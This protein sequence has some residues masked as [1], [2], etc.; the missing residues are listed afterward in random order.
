MGSLP[1]PLH[2]YSQTSTVTNMRPLYVFFW[3]AILNIKLGCCIQCVVSGVEKK[4]CPAEVATCAIRQT[5]DTGL[6]TF[7][8]KGE[9]GC[10]VQSAGLTCY[11]NS[12]NCNKD[13]GSAGYNVAAASAGGYTDIL[14]NSAVP[15]SISLGLLVVLLLL[16]LR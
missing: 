6:I 8:E 14:K 10:S 4:I 16:T 9:V 13:L 11:C 5:A 7:C 12:N 1:R 3:V 2:H 15:A